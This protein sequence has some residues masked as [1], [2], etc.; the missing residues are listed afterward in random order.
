MS[1]WGRR[2]ATRQMTADLAVPVAEVQRP[3]EQ[4]PTAQQGADYGAQETGGE[5]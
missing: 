4:L 3:T 1:R 2:A 5:Q